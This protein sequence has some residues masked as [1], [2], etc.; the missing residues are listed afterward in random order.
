MEIKL[1]RSGRAK[2]PTGS[3]SWRGRRG[4]RCRGRRRCSRRSGWRGRGSGGLRLGGGIDPAGVDAA[5]EG[6]G[7]F[8]VD[9]GAEP[10][11]AAECRL[12]MAA[13]AS[14]PLIEIE[15]AEGRI[16]VVAPHQADDPPTK[17]DAFRISGRAVDRLRGFDEFV[18]LALAVLGG[19]PRSGLLLGGVILSPAVAALGDGGSDPDKQRQRRDGDALKNCN[20]K[21]G[22]NPT[23]EIPN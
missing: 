15:M 1:I 12:D 22:T 20:S 8:G 9:G 16:E 10:H 6:F 14:E 23:H 11:H 2:P 21:P 17:P 3:F 19:I 7:D 5:V 13:G 4:C 18:R